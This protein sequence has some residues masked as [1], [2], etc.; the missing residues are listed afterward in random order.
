MLLT[1]ESRHAAQRG[2]SNVV[3]INITGMHRVHCSHARIAL[4]ALPPG[5][6]N[7]LPPSNLC[8]QH[9]ETLSLIGSLEASQHSSNCTSYRS[10]QPAPVHLLAHHCQPK[11]Q[12]CCLLQALRKSYLPAKVPSDMNLFELSDASARNI[13]NGAS[14][15]LLANVDEYNTTRLCMKRMI[16]CGPVLLRCT[17]QPGN[18]PWTRMPSGEICVPGYRHQ[19]LH[20]DPTAV[21]VNV[22]EAVGTRSQH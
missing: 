14:L 4:L 6:P 13:T 7:V 1:Q 16:G 20:C 18:Q 22:G 12:L 19:C 3:C 9:T 2:H 5:T 21:G 10:P 15:M 17:A 8:R 11:R